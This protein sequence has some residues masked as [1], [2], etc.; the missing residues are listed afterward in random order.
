MDWTG[1]PEA[2]NG[3]AVRRTF[4]G[5]SSPSRSEALAGAPSRTVGSLDETFGL[6]AGSSTVIEVLR[7]SSNY[8]SPVRRLWYCVTERM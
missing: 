1:E 2:P 4:E 5:G 8:R 3:S 6:V 7:E